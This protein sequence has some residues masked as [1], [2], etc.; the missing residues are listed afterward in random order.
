MF[1]SRRS[2][3]R[4]PIPLAA[5]GAAIALSA[6]VGGASSAPNLASAPNVANAPAP[7]T[8]SP[9]APAPARLPAA[10]SSPDP[11]DD[12]AGA[13]PVRATT[14]TPP[15]DRL[16]DVDT[17]R[18]SAA[19]FITFGFGP[20]SGEPLVPQGSLASAKP[21]FTLNNNEVVHILGS[22]FL[23]I[24]FEGLLLVDEDGNDTLAGPR[25]LKPRLP[26]LKEL[27]TIDESEGVMVWI[28][29]YTGGGCVS[30]D[31]SEKGGT[32]AVRIEHG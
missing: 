5:L 16:I 27:R 9:T 10:G 13:C 29:G 11:L 19:D 24:R 15:S 8:A 21:P 17:S 32:V 18:T 14:V 25:D 31:V 1:G 30:V 6:C 2:F 20:V 3:V 7:A 22:R 4:I 26:A 23:R 12:T 28:A